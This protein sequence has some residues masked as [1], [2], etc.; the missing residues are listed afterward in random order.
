MVS[1]WI[2][3]TLMTLVALAFVLVPLLRSR[4][5]AAPTATEANLDVLREQRR[6]IELD[7]AN[8]TLPASARDEALADLVGRAGEDLAPETAS[9]PAAARRPWFAAAATA[10]A[11]PAIAFGLY[12]AI[13]NPAATNP[14]VT[15]PESAQAD[16]KQIL[17]MVESLAKKVRDRPDDAQ[18]WALLARSMA[19]LGRFEEASDAYAHLVKL[20]P[21]DAQVL[22]DYA[23]TLGMA[24][25]R[26]LAG[27]PLELARE[28]LRI[29]P[30]NLKA[31]ALAGTAALDSGDFAA[32]I[33]HWEKL[34]AALPPDSADAA[35]VRSVVEEIR[36]RAAAAGRPERAGPKAMAKAPAAPG[37]TVSGSVSLSP[38]LASKVAGTE[39]LFIFARAEGGPRVPLA[40]VRASARQLPM[41]FTLDDTQA[42]APGMNLSSAQAVRVEA[43]V[44][45]SGNAS[46]QPGDLVGTSGVVKPGARGLR[47]VVDKELP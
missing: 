40:V 21:N 8:G 1:F 18:G 7:I 28:A 39:T 12:L 25:G 31:L 13:G 38:A 15:L 32:A 2:L 35:Q 6:E 22:A 33:G 46:P 42:M 24:Q 9:P 26:T 30:M 20:V 34:A 43:R 36:G 45:R 41:Q 16:D 44:S 11:I 17:A 23:D 10:V 27:R 37:P 14:L 4:A 19:A 5:A 29:D 47:I 3:A